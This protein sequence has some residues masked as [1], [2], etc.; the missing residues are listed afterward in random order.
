[1]AWLCSVGLECHFQREGWTSKKASGKR[2]RDHHP[3]LHRPSPN[4]LLPTSFDRGHGAA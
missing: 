2:K 4:L 1:M 3:C